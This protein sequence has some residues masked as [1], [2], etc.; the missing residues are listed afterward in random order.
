KLKSKA[1]LGQEKEEEHEQERR[2]ELGFDHF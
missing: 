1:K 2:E